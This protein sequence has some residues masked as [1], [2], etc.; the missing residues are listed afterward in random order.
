MHRD[1]NNWFEL[2]IDQA[3]R[4]LYMG[5][6]G[7]LEDGEEPGVDY[8]MA[9]NIIKGL[10]F[11]ESKNKKPITIIMNNPGGSW[12]HGMAIYDAILYSS[13]EVT[14]KVYGYAMSMGSIIL[15]AAKTRILMPNSSFMIHYGTDGM[16]SH[17]KVFEKWGDESKK[18][19]HKMEEIYL[20]SIIK[21]DKLD[22]SLE[23]N[24][25]SIINEQRLLEYP[26]TKPIKIKLSTNRDTRKEQIREYLKVLLNFDTILTPY[27]T[28]SLGLADKVF[29]K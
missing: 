25:S 9:E 8:L 5:S 18:N 20:D 6:V 29:S 28:V 11:L 2:G 16:S 10:L 24:L 21:F 14:I 22:G 7:Q 13:C 12:Y 1:P 4:I 27:Q 17:S 15:Q 19:N 3:S 23:K 26:P